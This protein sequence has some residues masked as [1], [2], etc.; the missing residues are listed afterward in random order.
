[1]SRQLIA[2][3]TLAVA[4]TLILQLALYRASNKTTPAKQGE[5]ARHSRLYRLRHV[6]AETARTLRL[7][8]DATFH[9]SGGC[10]RMVPHKQHPEIGNPHPRLPFVLTAFIRQPTQTGAT[11][12]QR[13]QTG[14]LLSR[15]TCAQLSNQP[16]MC[17]GPVS[18]LGHH[19]TLLRFGR[20]AFSTAT[21]ELIMLS[22][23]TWPTAVASRARASSVLHS[24][25]A[26][27]HGVG[28]PS[29]AGTVSNQP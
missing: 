5:V 18:V 19:R 13:R 12:Q 14:R 10:R 15:F 23:T 11:R 20:A 8:D 28:R 25:R 1:M 29:P 9:A 2:A 3:S 24:D 17:V 21:V 26:Q 4:C 27:Q 7:P 6:E 22:C 16:D